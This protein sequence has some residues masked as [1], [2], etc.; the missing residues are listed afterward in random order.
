M[1][2]KNMISVQIPIPNKILS[3]E[4]DLKPNMV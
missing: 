3:K 2:D 1:S 4:E